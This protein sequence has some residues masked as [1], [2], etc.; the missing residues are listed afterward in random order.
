[1]GIASID[2]ARGTLLQ[3]FAA[4]SA[5]ELEAQLALAAETYPRY[6][7][8]AFAQ[9][10]YW[11]RTAAELLEEQKQELA[12]MM[13]LE[14][15]K[16]LRSS[17]AEVEKCALI[18][19][20][21]ADQGEGLLAD[22]LIPTEA[23]RSFV[24]YQPLGPVL[25]VMPWNF[26][27]WQVFRFAAPALMAGNVGLLKPASNV[28]RCGLAIARIL[29]EAGFPEGAFQ[30]LLIPGSQVAAVIADDR[31]VAATLT[32]SEAAGASLAAAAGKALKPTVLELGGSDPFIVTANADLDAAVTTA[33]TARLGN[34]GQTCIA[35]KRFILVE[36]IAAAFTQ[37]LV[38]RF[39]ALKLGDPLDPEVDLGPLATPQILADL[40]RQVQACVAAGATV[41][42]G[43]Q[44]A[45]LPGQLAGAT[46]IQPRS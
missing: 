24:R 8:T 25:A 22:E 4:L 45:H 44:R 34:N 19:R 46:S 33:V 10:A 9:R 41:L 12:Q 15:G 35:A 29:R 31:V 6:R 26:P 39:Q 30:T 17:V 1:M 5:A 37:P 28:P 2:P 21:Y 43:G 20:Y 7:T 38:A 36:S 3:T 11:L 40:E 16:L 42:T 13:T 27:L 18:C 32:G 14:M 23:S